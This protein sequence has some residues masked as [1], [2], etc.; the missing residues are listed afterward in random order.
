MY[1]SEMISNGILDLANMSKVQEQ[2]IFAA[3]RS[4]DVGAEERLI[5]SGLTIVREVADRC[6]SSAISFAALFKELKSTVD[7]AIRS[8][9]VSKEQSFNS[10][11]RQCLEEGVKDC[12]SRLPLFLPIDYRIVQLHDRFEL[13][14]YELYPDNEERHSDEAHDEEYVADYLGVSREELRAMKNEYDLCTVQSLDEPVFVDEPTLSD[15]DDRFVPFIE[16]IAD[17]RSNERA[18]DYL[19]TLMDC[20]NDDERYVVCSMSGV[21][22]AP[23]R[24]EAQIAARLGIDQNAVGRLYKRA[25]GKIKQAGG[26]T[27]L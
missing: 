15:P 9:D 20:L 1:Q 17:P 11:L 8:F 7:E 23:Q 12:Y 4:G 6:Q 13:A 21:L 26:K 2:E 14:L 10:Y 16:T 3:I 24:T 25:L 18:A 5:Q 27:I 19:D 22:S